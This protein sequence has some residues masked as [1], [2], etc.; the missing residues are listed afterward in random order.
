VFIHST[1]TFKTWNGTSGYVDPVA[2]VLQLRLWDSSGSLLGSSSASVAS[3][4]SGEVE[5]AIQDAT[6]I[7]SGSEILYAVYVADAVSSYSDPMS[8]V[9]GELLRVTSESSGF[10]STANDTKNAGETNPV[11]SQDRWS[12]NESSFLNYSLTGLVVD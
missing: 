7:E 12:V 5:F 8:G 11:D 6:V 9:R 1:K 10:V 4:E 3:G 2:V